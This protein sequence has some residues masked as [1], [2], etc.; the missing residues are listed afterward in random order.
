MRPTSSACGCQLCATASGLLARALSLGR[1]PIPDWLSDEHVDATVQIGVLRLAD[2][3]ARGIQTHLLWDA[4]KAE[5][6]N[7][8]A[9]IDGGR[10]TGTL[11]VNLRGSLPVYRLEAQCKGIQWKSGTVEA[12]TV[13]ES[14]GT[15]TELLARLHSAGTFAASGLEMD[16]LPDLE[17]V[18]GFYDIV[19]AQGRAAPA[20]LGATT[21]FGER[22]LYEEG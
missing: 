20:L 7:L 4:T 12:E 5:F 6:D 2:A 11:S 1:T 8:R 17:S 22:H 16:A 13:L 14:S 18:S 10:V 9:R 15:G 21:G 3:E 19:W